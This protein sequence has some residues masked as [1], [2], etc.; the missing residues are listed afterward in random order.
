V[1]ILGLFVFV[2]ALIILSLYFYI[3]VLILLNKD[4][5]LNKVKNKYVLLYVKYII[6]KTKIDFIFI[7]LITL[8]MLFFMAYILHY[9]IAATLA[10][11]Y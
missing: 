11:Y 2:S 6:F 10:L 1:I 9:L 7:G 4:Y 5:F 3:N 8:C